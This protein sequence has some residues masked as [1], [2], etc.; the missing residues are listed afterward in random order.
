MTGLLVQAV[1]WFRLVPLRTCV[2]CRLTAPFEEMLKLQLERVCRPA[3]VPPGPGP[4]ASEM[5][6]SLRRVPSQTRLQRPIHCQLRFDEMDT[7]WSASLTV[8][9]CA[10]CCLLPGAELIEGFHAGRKDCIIRIHVRSSLPDRCRPFGRAALHPA[11]SSM[12]TMSPP[13]AVYCLW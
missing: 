6:S 2:W 4:H 3:A 9:G 8:Y 11:S 7:I 1:P 5:F 12:S 10:H 13:G